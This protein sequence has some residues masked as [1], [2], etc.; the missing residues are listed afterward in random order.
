VAFEALALPGCL[1]YKRTTWNKNQTK[2][3]SQT[4]HSPIFHNQ[5]PLLLYVQKGAKFVN[6]W[7]ANSISNWQKDVKGFSDRNM[8]LC[9][10][11]IFL[12]EMSGYLR[13]S[14]LLNQQ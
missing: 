13:S 5:N 10:R 4:N 2:G 1:T 14:I 7:S 9:P 11:A 3:N 6:F 8:K 12:P